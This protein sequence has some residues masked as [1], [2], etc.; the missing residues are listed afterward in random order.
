MHT[1]TIKQTLVSGEW[2]GK[3]MYGQKEAWKIVWEG[4]RGEAECRVERIIE[5]IFC[6]C[7][8]NIKK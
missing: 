4:G 7:K 1:Q 3:D 8:K 2:A 6:L 5:I